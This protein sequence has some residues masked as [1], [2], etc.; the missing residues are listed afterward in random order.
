MGSH[1][2][3]DYPSHL[4]LPHLNQRHSIQLRLPICTYRLLEDVTPDQEPAARDLLALFMI[5]LQ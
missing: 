4:Q 1:L 3:S 2:S 5:P